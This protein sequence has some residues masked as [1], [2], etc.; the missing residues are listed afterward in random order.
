MASGGSIAR[1]VTTTSF[2]RGRRR[3]SH[4]G[5]IATALTIL[6][7]P[8]AE[9][10][11]HGGEVTRPASVTGGVN[12]VR[13]AAGEVVVPFGNLTVSQTSGPQTTDLGGNY[14]FDGVGASTALD[15]PFIDLADTCD[16][17][18][19][20][21]DGDG[22]IALGTSSAS[23]CAVA[24]SSS[25]TRA[26]R[27]T[28]YYGEL[29]RQLAAKWLPSNT[30]LQSQIQATVNFN[31][32][33]APV[34]TGSSMQLVSSGGGC[35]NAGEN[36]DV[37]A[38]VFFQGLDDNDANGAVAPLYTHLG[39]VDAFVAAMTHEACVA[40]GFLPNNDG[41]TEAC[42]TAVRDMNRDVTVA[43]AESECPH[44]GI[45]G[46]L[47][48]R[49]DCESHIVSGSLWDL[50]AA[51]V[52]RYGEEEGWNRYERLLL[53][54]AG[55][56][57]DAY[58]SNGD[59]GCA[60]DGLYLNLLAA[61]DDDVNLNNGTPN[62]DIIYAA[63]NGHGIACTTPTV[64]Q[65]V[66][67]CPTL[68]AAPDVTIQGGYG[69]NEL[70][71]ESVPN[72]DGYRVFRRLPSTGA[73]PFLPVGGL[74]IAD[75]FSDSQVHAGDTYE[76]QVV[77]VDGEC[78]SPFGAPEVAT[79]LDD[80]APP[81]TAMAKPAKWTKTK[82]FLVSWS[83]TDAGSGVF[84]YDVRVQKAPF[85]GGFGPFTDFQTNTI[86]EEG[87]LEGQPGNTYCFE[88]RATDNAGNDSAFGSRRCTALPLDDAKLAHSKG[89][90]QLQSQ[91][92]YLGSL[93]Q[94]SK[95]GATLSKQVQAKRLALLVSK[96][97]GCGRLAVYFD[98]DLLK[99]VDL[100]GSQ[101]L[102][103]QLV[104]VK[105]FS[106]VRSGKVKLEVLDAGDKVL[107]DGLGVSRV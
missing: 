66:V 100:A 43:N 15:G 1:R 107:V 63:L 75:N 18:S 32:P 71:W 45:E 40:P 39:L 59:Y 70:S 99:K 47:G 35:A 8:S 61:D 86:D 14:S 52:N 54:G 23:D 38:G 51:L 69:T 48:R 87:T 103:K 19:G 106:A 74:I 41:E 13:G 94:S 33:C 67:D 101:T 60:A 83:A 20:E 95:K 56:V 50:A 46:P 89:W 79:V 7:I 2:P 30:W 102:K 5:L 82:S 11:A 25:T 27:T 44:G 91:G 42:P 57:D 81:I 68:P 73:K 17:P 4:R 28:F 12:R 58:Q 10:I 93:S 65:H 16:S 34:W 24:G 9:G 36:P 55:T 22:D 97:P 80:Q 90:N 21:A 26:A 29:A 72:A 85:S 62:M 31:E 49:F 77:A 84:S 64:Q 78:S 105:K 88:V 104:D 76:Y 37:V 92:N 6:L 96:C 53:Q 98:G 3:R